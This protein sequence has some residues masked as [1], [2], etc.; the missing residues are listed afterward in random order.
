MP[1]PEP[2]IRKSRLRAVATALA[3]ACLLALGAAIWWGPSVAL[4][5]AVQRGS[6]ALGFRIVSGGEAAVFLL[7]ARIGLSGFA[8]VRGDGVPVRLG[9]ADIAFDWRALFDGRIELPTA[10]LS[11]VAVEISRDRDGRFRIAGLPVG[12][13]DGTQGDLPMPLRIGALELAD[14]RLTL[15]LP[16]GDREILV[17]TLSLRGLALADPA[18]RPRLEFVA[19]LDGRKLRFDGTVAPFAAAPSV[20]GRIAAGRLALGGLAGIFGVAFGGTLDGEA[21]IVAD[22]TG[23]VR[24]DGGFALA[25]AS[26]A[27]ARAGAIAWRGKATRTPAGDLEIDGRVDLQ[28]PAF[29]QGGLAAGAASA[30]FDGRIALPAGKPPTASGTLTLA[31]ATLALPGGISAASDGAR[32]ELDGFALGADGTLAGNAKI[33]TQ[34][35]AAEI[36][37]L[38]LRAETARGQ[39][40]IAASGGTPSFDGTLELTAPAAQDGDLRVSAARAAFATL[41]YGAER[42]E[43][44]VSADA[45]AVAAADLALSAAR[46]GF[47]GSVGLRDATLGAVTGRLNA[48]QLQADLQAAGI[49]MSADEMKFE[50]NGAFAGTPAASGALSARG[51]AVAETGGRDLFAAADAALDAFALEG[52]RIRARRAAFVDA[53]LLRQPGAG[54]AA[55][56]WRVEA[57]RASLADVRVEIGG[58]IA[59]AVLRLERATL[60]ATR[61]KDGLLGL[62]RADGAPESPSPGFALGRIDLVDAR[63]VFE[64]RTP[65]TTVRVPFERVYGAFGDL[66]DRRPERPTTLSLSARV[67]GFG[68]ARARGT[69]FPFQPRLSFDIEFDA[70]T[71]DLPPL[72]PYVEEALGSAL[73]TGTATVEGRLVARD[74]ALEGTTKWRLSNVQVDERSAA[75][76]AL[77]QSAGVSL[78]TALSLVADDSGDIELDI[79]IAGHLYDPTFDTGD[80]VRQAVGG[81]LRGAISG[82]LSLLFPIGAIFSAALDAERRGTGLVLPAVEFAPGSASLAGAAPATVD[83]LAKLLAA[84]PAARL[85]VCGYAGPADTPPDARAPDDDGLR[86][87]AAARAEAVKRRLVGANSIEASRVFECRPTVEEA[88]V[89]LPRA[90]LRF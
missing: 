89:A 54:G 34:A 57:P 86:A 33:E 4:R 52:A 53:K 87:L 56:S 83:G 64:D 70:R 28:A 61:T 49:R 38:K 9:R 80:A 7:D 26:H 59:A 73:R 58:A 78:A 48:T 25:D 62:D 66:D 27:G 11:G 14:V 31:G 3:T 45:L 43:A 60:R 5:Q 24:I 36:A 72:S 12:G 74:E 77:E 15:R 79:P 35:L 88:I 37:A 40:R 17:E 6:D 47:D 69:L 50:G 19:S 90:E 1:Q 23:L 39:G 63:G 81:A 42:I 46:L 75:A 55:Y 51:L 29:A 10:R 85:E 67:G 71:V 84:R 30:G 2:Q 16:G 20:D 18:S 13:G 41:R 8:A 68:D 44:V 65:R 76:G 21:D 32:L 22:A 82:T